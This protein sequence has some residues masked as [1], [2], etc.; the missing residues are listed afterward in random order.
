MKIIGGYLRSKGT[1]SKSAAMFVLSKQMYTYTSNYHVSIIH[2]HRITICHPLHRLESDGYDWTTD[3]NLNTY[4][5]AVHEKEPAQARTL[6]GYFKTR[7]K[8]HEVKLCRLE[9]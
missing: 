1:F 4:F 7:E 6:M 8:D 2:A 5:S 3:G 9:P